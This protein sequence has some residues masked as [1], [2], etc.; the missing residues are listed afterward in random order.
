[1]TEWYAGEA[2]LLR[3]IWPD[4]QFMP[5]GNWVLKP[6]YALPDGWNRDAVDLAFRIPPN[7]PGEQPYAFWVRGGLELASGGEIGNY[8]FP[9]ETLPFSTDQWGKFSWAP[10]TWSPGTAP[11]R[12]DG[13]VIFVESFRRRLEE[14]S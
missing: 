14:L 3:S 6:A 4:L 8:Q 10:I 13:M 7:M 12:G 5:E 2:D 1:M 9:S 11:G